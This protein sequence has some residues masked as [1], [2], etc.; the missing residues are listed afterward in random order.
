MNATMVDSLRLVLIE[1]P[2]RVLPSKYERKKFFL[3]E[4]RSAAK[5]NNLNTMA[6]SNAY[7]VVMQP[8]CGNYYQI[9]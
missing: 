4:I 7:S 3:S 1:T 6:K 8:H 2:A 9:S 5:K